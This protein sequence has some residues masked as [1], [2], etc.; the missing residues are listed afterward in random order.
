MVLER[1]KGEHMESCH[2]SH[3]LHHFICS[4]QENLSQDYSSYP[5]SLSSFYLHGLF[6]KVPIPVS[7]RLLFKCKL[8]KIKWNLKFTSS[9]TLATFQVFNNSTCGYWPLYWMVQTDSIVPL[10][11]KVLS[12]CVPGESST[13]SIYESSVLLMS[14]WSQFFKCILWPTWNIKITRIH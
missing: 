4:S 3:A 13:L 5:W 8:V 6:N 7:Q 9:F 14:F 1:K 12:D 2:T 10:T 11:Q